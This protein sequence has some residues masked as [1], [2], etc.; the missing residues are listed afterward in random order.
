VPQATQDPARVRRSFRLQGSNLLWP[1]I[2][3]RSSS[4]ARPF[5]WRSY[6]PSRRTG[7]FGLFPVR[8]PLLRESRLISFPA[9]TE[10]FQFPALAPRGLWIQPAV[11]GYDPCRV[12]P[13]GNPRINGCLHLPEAYRS[14]P[15][16]SSLPR[17]K[18][19]ALRP[20]LLDFY[21]QLPASPRCPG[22][23]PRLARPRPGPNLHPGRNARETRGPDPIHRFPALKAGNLVS[24]NSLGAP[25]QRT[26]GSRPARLRAES[27]CSCQ[28]CRAPAVLPACF[29]PHAR[30]ALHQATCNRRPLSPAPLPRADPRAG[31]GLATG[32][33]AGP[34]ALT[35]W[36]IPGSN[37]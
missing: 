36:R 15:R 21:F 3:G 17:A 7:W 22:G 33:L 16:P 32:A 9:G 18:A 2:P 24:T 23:A 27:P 28:P 30:S 6:N 4:Q 10:M 20:F 19:S 37:R 11:T 35:W 25:C 5:R 1:A 8:S 12:A 26:S 13:F 14:L 31:P 29:L 34:A